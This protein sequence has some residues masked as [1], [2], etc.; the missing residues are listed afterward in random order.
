VGNWEIVDRVE[1]HQ[2]I[3]FRT[4]LTKVGRTTGTT[5]IGVVAYRNVTVSVDPWVSGGL[6]L[7]QFV[8]RGP[9][10]SGAPGDSGSPVFQEVRATSAHL[11]GVLWAAAVVDNRLLLFHSPVF[12]FEADLRVPP[13]GLIVT[14]RRGQ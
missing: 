13:G 5:R 6:K 14:P 10:V 4:R 9:L 1:D 12:G 2:D 11:F 3:R 8:T 7:G